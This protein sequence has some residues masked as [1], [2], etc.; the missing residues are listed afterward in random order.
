MTR[1]AD[2]AYPHR[3]PAFFLS[4]MLPRKGQPFPPE[5]RNC[6]HTFQGVLQFRLPSAPQRYNTLDFPTENRVPTG[7]LA[8]LL[9]TQRQRDVPF[10]IPHFLRRRICKLQKQ[11]LENKK[12]LQSSPYNW[13]KIAAFYHTQC[14]QKVGSHFNSIDIRYPI[15]TNITIT[16][17]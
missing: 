13:T 10:E 8:P 4:L 2:S 6:G 3:L 14:K 7:M 11:Q 9:E 17:R 16:E 12:T 1:L 5:R 15:S